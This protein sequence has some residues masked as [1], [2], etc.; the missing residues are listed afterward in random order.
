MM[1]HMQQ[2][3]GAA[4]LAAQ[5]HAQV[6]AGSSRASQAAMSVG[7]GRAD[8]KPPL[9]VAK[10]DDA[11]GQPHMQQAA[12][13]VASE[14]Q[15]RKRYPIDSIFYNHPEKAQAPH[16][17]TTGQLPANH[18]R[19]PQDAKY[20]M[21][22]ADDFAT[23][24]KDRGA[25]YRVQPE[26]MCATLFLSPFQPETCAQLFSFPLFIGRRVHGR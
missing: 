4:A 1:E 7:A 8:G 16:K 17:W 14:N 23:Y 11:T 12:S 6:V 9:K 3:P 18:Y 26:N 15:A 10:T 20:K 13:N 24:W 19:R 2:H 5:Q 21:K 22:P 25:S